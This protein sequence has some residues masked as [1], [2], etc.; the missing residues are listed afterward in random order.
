VWIVLLGGLLFAAVGLVAVL[1][2][3]RSPHEPGLSWRTLVFLAP[4]IVGLIVPARA[5]SA[6]SGQASSLGALQLAS[7]VSSGTSGDAFGTWVSDLSSHPDPNW[8][9]GQH[10]TLVGFATRQVGLPAH[11]FIIGRYLVTCCVVD[12][13]LLGFPVQLARGP[14]PPQGAWIQVSGVFGRRYWTDPSGAQ[15][16]V[17]EHAHLAP[18]SVPSS[19]YLSP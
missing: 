9:A 1:R 13:T 18:V 16:P 19:P 12:A 14:L 2:A 3:W 7:H 11:S 10:V 8:W 17:I 6:T 5:L 4:V 15:Y